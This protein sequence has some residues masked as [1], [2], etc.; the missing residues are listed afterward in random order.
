MAQKKWQ[1]IYEEVMNNL[2]SESQPS[3]KFSSFCATILHL[4]HTLG[5]G[6]K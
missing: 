3:C 2:I 5:K 6:V 4:I 1:T